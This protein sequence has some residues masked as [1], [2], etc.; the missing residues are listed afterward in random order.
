MRVKAECSGLVVL[1]PLSCVPPRR[2]R[3]EEARRGEQ[4]RGRKQQ[5]P[6]GKG[7]P[8]PSFCCWLSWF[9]AL[10]ALE[11]LRGGRPINMGAST[12]PRQ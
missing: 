9:D 3:H 4:Q 7:W 11:E 10:A 8:T 12:T 5:R 6:R 2:R 1:P